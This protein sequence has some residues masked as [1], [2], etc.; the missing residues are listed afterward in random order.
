MSNYREMRVWSSH[1]TL[2]HRAI[3]L[4]GDYYQSAVQSANSLNTPH[5]K[6]RN[7]VS[8]PTL[9]QHKPSTINWIR[10]E[11]QIAMFGAKKKKKWLPLA[12]NNQ[13]DKVF[14]STVFSWPSQSDRTAYICTTHR[15]CMHHDILR[16]SDVKLNE[17]M[18]AL[19]HSR[20]TQ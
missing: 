10:T 12:L 9:P 17:E 20:C 1:E 13:I 14:A 8:E 2:T 7:Y 11:H 3:D 4:N 6:Y 5:T 18:L 15:H 16:L 19:E